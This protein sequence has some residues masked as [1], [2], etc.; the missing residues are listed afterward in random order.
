MSTPVP[1]P[2]FLTCHHEV[3]NEVGLVGGQGIQVGTRLVGAYWG[4]GET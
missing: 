2:V 1:S 4:N 3:L